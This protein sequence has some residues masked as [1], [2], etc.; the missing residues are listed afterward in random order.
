M[1]AEDLVELLQ[2]RTE[3][4]DLVE[5]ARVFRVVVIDDRAVKLLVRAARF[6]YLGE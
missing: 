5:D 3:I 6:P 4:G 2:S 1:R